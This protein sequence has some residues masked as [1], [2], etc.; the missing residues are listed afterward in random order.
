MA[1]NAL[2]IA[3]EG[4]CLEPLQVGD[5]P[6]GAWCDSLSFVLRSSYCLSQ[7]SAVS[8]L[9][10]DV[11]GEMLSW[12]GSS[13]CLGPND[14]E[15][16]QGRHRFER[17]L[18]KWSGCERAFVNFQGAHMGSKRGA[19]RQCFQMVASRCS[20]ISCLVVRNWFCIEHSGLPA[21][22]SSF[23]KLR[24]LELTGCEQISTYSIMVPVFEQH[25]TLLSLRAG[26][27]PRAVAGTDFAQAAPRT[28]VALGFVNFDSIE[29]LAILLERCSLEHCWFAAN[30]VFTNVVLR[31]GLDGLK[32]R[33]Q[34]GLQQVRTLSLPSDMQED[35]CANLVALCPQVQL[36]CRMRIASSEFGT[37]LLA[38]E[39]EPVPE[40]GGVVVRRHGSK[41][42]LAANGALWA[43]YR[44]GDNDIATLISARNAK[45]KKK[46]GWSLPPASWWGR[47]G[48]SLNW[49]RPTLDGPKFAA[50]ADELA[51]AAAARR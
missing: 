3:W 10:R 50:F 45:A 19:A 41:A 18:P 6:I 8:R 13:V 22:A 7:V 47:G 12:Q 25:P 1:P 37:G 31:T 29:P 38:A 15:V 39:F 34:S 11:S 2:E 4:S 26:F 43:P 5:L 46:Q 30:S 36:V 28:L 9:F 44:Q 42:N 35:V 16:F 14:L 24:H 21:L 27:H 20:D 33:L 23:P 17:L 51:V 40:G 48:S 32:A 49:A